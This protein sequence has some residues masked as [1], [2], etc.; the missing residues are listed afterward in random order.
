MPTLIEKLATSEGLTPQEYLITFGYPPNITDETKRKYLR[1]YG[2][3]ARRLAES[4]MLVAQT[5][6]KVVH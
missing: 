4:M 1:K 5:G 6:K 2:A 3:G